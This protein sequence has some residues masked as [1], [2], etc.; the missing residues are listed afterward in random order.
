[1]RFKDSIKISFIALRAN[2]SRSVLTMSG[3]IIGV[4]AVIIMM[5]LGSGAQNL[6][7]GQIA[8]TGS[9]S[10][11]I[12]PGSFDPSSGGLGGGYESAIEEMTVK[13]M[14]I[15]DAVDI[16]KDPLIEK[17]APYVFGV[18]RAVY[19]NEDEK[20]TYYGTTSDA[21]DI[22]ELYTVSG[23]ELTDEDVR[24]MAK[25]A[26]LGNK[27][28]KDL[29]GEEDPIGKKI[30]IKNVNLKVIGIL[31]EKGTQMFV[32]VDELIYMPITTAQKLLLGNDETR[33]IIAKA[34]NENVIPQAIENIRLTM[35]ENHG[36]YNPEGDL[37]KDDFKVM[38]QVE[39]ADMMAQITGI[40]TAF[41][42]SVAAI[43]L[44]VGG[45]GIMN[46]MLVSVTERTREIGL[47]KAV[48]ARNKDILKQ[49]LIES[50]TLTV[51]GG[52]IGFIGGTFFSF[53]G[54]IALS[55]ALNT[56][57]SFVMPFGAVVLAFG[58]AIIVGLVFGIY[59]ARKASKLNPIE[60]LRHE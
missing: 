27:L 23:R 59:P 11:Y 52:F 20:I 3:I 13:T 38:S 43:A 50:V 45:I 2:K 9:T 21:H 36:I 56:D 47:R 42:S 24:S 31:E 17:A 4:G 26:I 30:R 58:M 19:K 46:I 57:W 16:E 14:K 60:A 28:A 34:V 15:K 33:W 5:G 22:E 35:R 10:I 41:L 7:I 37:S 55:K 25:V 44:V 53:I 18:G 6:I 49:F 39:A 54:A 1:M 29:F 12:E 32:N 8:S 48:G 40:L 51:L